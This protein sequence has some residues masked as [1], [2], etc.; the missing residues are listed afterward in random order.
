MAGAGDAERWVRMRFKGHEVFVACDA[1]GTP[2][3]EA[4]R[5]RIRYP[6]SPERT[7]RGA[8]RHLAPLGRRPQGAAPPAASFA[9]PR[10]DAEAASAP[11]SSAAPHREATAGRAQAPLRR[12]AAPA[13]RPRRA[14]V[15]DSD[16]IVVYTDGACQGNPGPSGA[17]IVVAW[18]PHR[19][20]KSLYL[21]R[22]TNN[23]AELTAILEALRAIRTPERRVELHT[24]SR[25]AVGVLDGSFRVRANRELVA[26]IQEQMARFPRLVLHWVPGHAGDPDNERADALAREAIARRASRERRFRT[27]EAPPAEPDG[28]R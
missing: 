25:Y 5:V 3:V 20:E 16:T 26:R 24:D 18:G 21:G 1:E 8:V 7:Y 22:G 23:T 27:D 2:L 19:L 11:A 10:R 28:E 13:R 15:A 9:A 4:G 14:A 17:G 6:R 12:P